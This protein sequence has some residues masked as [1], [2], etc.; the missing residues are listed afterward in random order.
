MTDS[1]LLL[2]ALL[3]PPCQSALPQQLL[4]C[5]G[6]CQ[7]TPALLLVLLVRGCCVAA[8]RDNPGRSFRC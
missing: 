8:G 5:P 7:L 1:H 3:L 6:C 2:L 4:A